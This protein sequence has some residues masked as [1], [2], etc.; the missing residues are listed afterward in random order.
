MVMAAGLGSALPAL[1]AGVNSPPVLPHSIISFPERDFISADGYTP[2]HP[3]VVN[4]LRNGFVVST[5]TVDPLDDISTPDVVEG[6]VE[7]NHPG[8]G[9]WE[10]VTP[11][12]RPGDVI[13]ILTGPGEGDST[14]TA[15]VIVTQPAT[16]ID[17]T[18]VQ[19]KGTAVTPGGAQIPV[20]Q[21]EARVIAPNQRFSNGKRSIRADFTGAA[22]GTLAYDTPAG[23]SWTATFRL[24]GSIDGLSDADRAV[25]AQNESRGMWLGGTPAAGN[26]LTIFEAGAVGGPSLPC[27]APA[28]RGPSTPDLLAISDSGASATDNITNVATPTFG[29]NRD[30]TTADRIN[31]YVDGVLAGSTTAIA[32][33]GTWAVAPDAPLTNGVH[34][35]TAGESSAGG[36]ETMGLGSLQVTVDTVAPA[37][38]V[39]TGKPAAASSVR[40]P[41]FTFTGEAGAAFTCGLT[42]GAAAAACVSGK[43]FGPLADGRYTFTLGVK[44][45]AGNA[46]P[47]ATAAFAVGVTPTV[48]ARTPLVNQT[49]IGQT[50]NITATMSRAVNATTVNRTSFLLKAPNGTVVPAAVTYNATTRVATLNPTATLAADTRY[51]ASL[52][53]AVKSADFGVGLTPTAWAFVTGPA[54]VVNFRSPA[55]GAVGVSRLS[56]VT[57]GFNEAI[58]GVNGTTVSLRSPSGAV[59][60]AV[61]TYNATTRRATLNPSVTL[62]PRTRY[63]LRL[64]AGIKDRAGNALTAT[65]WSFTTRA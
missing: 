23:T 45:R 64:T 65:S 7:V 58:T 11:N 31:L 44:D 52:T 35:I 28:E 12:I 33:N 18:T 42:P 54:P 5:A 17:A 29:G 38:G 51:T 25:N 50:A 49:R 36:A 24:P 48:T 22:D 20:D 10:G 6:L 57:A 21:L 43:T 37:A 47:N 8:G 1:A 39:I 26:E 41:R 55:A 59:V 53:S 62:A 9:C 15:S 34:T 19:I 13:E 60:R 46:A 4:V 30:A 14:T 32:A 40:S 3:V 2:G 63:T 61:V 27:Q 16:K 56:N